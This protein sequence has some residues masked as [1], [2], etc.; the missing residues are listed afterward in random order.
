[1]VFKKLIKKISKKEDDVYSQVS[2]VEENEEKFYVS[3]E[4]RLKQN[5]KPNLKKV[6]V[7]TLENFA[8]LKDLLEIIREQKTICLINIKKMKS[9]DP[10]E[11]RRAIDKL[12]K[13][14]DAADGDLVA[15]DD[16]W[17]L[18]TPKDVLIEKNK[19][20]TQN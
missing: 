20:T 16:G 11:L 6:K 17:L 14:I 10:D 1:M 18:N 2:Q 12:R 3:I 5:E 9:E 19:K 13:T 15:F 7:Y 8:S 4:D